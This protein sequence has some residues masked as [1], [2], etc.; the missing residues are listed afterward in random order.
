MSDTAIETRQLSKYFGNFAAVDKVNLHVP[1]GTI[2]GYLGANGAGKTTTI[3][4]LLNLAKA[5]SGSISVLGQEVPSRFADVARRIGVVPGEV[6][7]FGGLNGRQALDYW[8]RFLPA[9]AAWRQKLCDDF[10]LTPRD[11]DKK[12]GQYSQGMKQKLILIQAMQHKPQLLILDEPSERLDPLMQSTLYNYVREFAA[13]G[14]TVFFSS[15][16]LAEVEKVC[17]HVGIIKDG[18]LVEQDS[19]ENLKKR[20][21]RFAKIWFKTPVDP[22]KLAGHFN[23]R[24]S[25]GHFMELEIDGQSDKLVK[26]LAQFDVA[27]LHIPPSSLEDYFMDFYREGNRRA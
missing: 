1:R 18:V 11:L 27:D 24:H 8:G 4:M 5:N 21:P 13:A 7:L 16:N 25:E 17:H 6:H 22:Q 9:D 14:H 23:I 10:K 20:L 26:L 3:R 15:H 12:I 2:Y 19:L